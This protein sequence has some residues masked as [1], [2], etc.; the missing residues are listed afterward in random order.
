MQRRHALTFAAGAAALAANGLLSSRAAAQD[1]AGHDHAAMMAA[2]KAAPAKPRK[3]DALVK[4]LSECMAAVQVCM[5]HCQVVL[6]TGDKSM[7][8]C[9]RTA[10]DCDVVC[11]AALKAAGLNSAYTPALAKTAQ[12]AMEACVKSCKPHIEHHAECKGCH[13]ACL[14]AIDAI[15]K[16]A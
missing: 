12:A 11:G 4:P 3:Y 5:N 15:R 7:G 1:H 10:L 9:L 16:M 6:A 13:D 14:V 2:A 8:D